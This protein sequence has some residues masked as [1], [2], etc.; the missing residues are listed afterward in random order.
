MKRNDYTPLNIIERMNSRISLM[1][2]VVS[3]ILLVLLFTW[4]D[5]RMI[6][7][8]AIEETA[9][10]E[11]STQTR[12]RIQEGSVI[13]SVSVVA[14]GDN[15]FHDSLIAG[16]K[17]DPNNWNYEHYYEY[18]KDSVQAADIAIVDQETIL[19]TDHAVATGY[20]R[21]ATPSEVADALAATGF[22]V[23]YSATNHADDY[24]AE[25]LKNTVNYW[26][27]AHPGVTLLGI[28]DSQEDADEIKIVETNGIKIAFL[29]YVYGTNSLG[30]GSS[31]AY[32]LDVFSI[33]S[34]K[35]AEK[36]QAAKEAA[37]C[38]VFIAHWGT[39]DEPM[40]NEYEKQ[41]AAFL[42]QQGVDVCI[43]GHPHTLQPYGYLSDDAGNEML[44]FYSLGNFMSGQKQFVELLEGMAS[45]S[46]EKVKKPDGTITVEI[47]DPVIRPMV[48][49]Y[50][51]DR[52]EFHVYFLE[53][54]TDELA[55][56]HG[57]RA[58]L[59]E[60][61]NVKNLKKKFKEIMSVNVKPSTGT[62]LLNVT[63]LW[64]GTLLDPL[65]NV[66]LNNDNELEY[67]Y[68]YKMGIDILDYDK[69]YDYTANYKD[70]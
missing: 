64:D 52:T 66:V 43:G 26:R 69:D 49:H 6:T 31:Q 28:H 13:S 21:F 4:I 59:G 46:I 10:A 5:Y 68:Y 34:E 9:A 33:G 39:E 36:I 14:V 25:Y 29:N 56:E 17:E 41:W 2:G 70:Q 45:F 47:T 22:N 38:V 63:Q 35:I 24:G 54:Y 58:E 40:P 32:M 67:Q 50:N 18:V 61:F 57:A 23:V 62:K 37:D 7:K 60:I 42:M 11:E 3:L 15:L 65:G 30:F 20:P 8:P 27:T 48:M 19:S 16:G 53:D 44:I 12:K 55:A 51:T 1:S